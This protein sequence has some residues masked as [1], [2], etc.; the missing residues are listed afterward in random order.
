MRLRSL[1]ENDSSL[2]HNTRHHKQG[3]NAKQSDL[4]PSSSG[5]HKSRRKSE[6]R[7]S[8]ARPFTS[9]TSNANRLNSA[10]STIL[11]YPTRPG[12]KISHSP[13]HGI[14]SASRS[15]LFPIH[16]PSQTSDALILTYK[17]RY[18]LSISFPLL[19]RRQLCYI[20]C[21]QL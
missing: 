14:F 16:L 12:L 13:T 2:L 9:S 4:W 17:P 6:A 11:A 15:S 7:D 3:A 8:I 21:A 20:K 18:P 19:P 10:R 1:V 5:S